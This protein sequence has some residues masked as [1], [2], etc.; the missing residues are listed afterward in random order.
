[1]NDLQQNE[2]FFYGSAKKA[3]IAFFI[4]NPEDF[5]KFSLA[6]DFSLPD[7][8]HPLGR[9]LEKFRAECGLGSKMSN[10][11]IN[12]AI[13]N[14]PTSIFTDEEKAIQQDMLKVLD[15]IQNSMKDDAQKKNPFPT[16]SKFN[17]LFAKLCTLYPGVVKGLA[18]P[19]DREHITNSFKR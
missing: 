14:V 12:K 18:S 5:I 2:G 19:E 15:K 11:I 13:D 17:A 6:K 1:M 7:S 3:L 16:Y 8:L 9:Y 10:S 4:K